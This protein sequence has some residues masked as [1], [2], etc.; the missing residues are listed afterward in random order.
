MNQ[1][2]DVRSR[3]QHSVGLL[4][5]SLSPL[6]LYD[7]LLITNKMCGLCGFP[8]TRFGRARVLGNCSKQ[9][10][11]SARFDAGN[12]A[13]CGG[14]T[15]EP[16]SRVRCA[17]RGTVGMGADLDAAQRLRATRIELRKFCAPCRYRT[18]KSGQLSSGTLCARDWH[19]Y[20]RFGLADGSVGRGTVT[21]RC[22][23]ELL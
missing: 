22:K 19:C 6:G 11:Q 20:L 16:S 18:V 1:T 23:K 21:K 13:G 10:S 4:C 3:L 8:V 5:S 9:A 12:M 7:M 17:V 14:K 2:H 15:R